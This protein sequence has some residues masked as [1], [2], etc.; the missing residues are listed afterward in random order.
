ML[1]GGHLYRRSVVCRNVI[2][3][4]DYLIGIAYLVQVPAPVPDDILIF[5]ILLVSLYRHDLAG[6][7]T[8]I[9][10]IVRPAF[11]IDQPVVYADFLQ[12][13]QPAVIDR[14]AQT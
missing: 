2:N 10:S 8:A 13:F 7:R 14:I 1:L 6:G 4:A 3:I 12:G 11:R 5:R 9:V